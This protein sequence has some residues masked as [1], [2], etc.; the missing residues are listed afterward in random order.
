MFRYEMHTHTTPCSACGVQTMSEAVAACAAAGYAG[1]VITN[2]FY[3]G[4]SG[5]SRSLAWEE[6]VEAYAADWREGVK[7]SKEAGIDVIF[8]LEEGYASGKEVLLYGVTPEEIAAAPFLREKGLEPLSAYVRSQGGL[9]VHAHPYR[10]ASYIP[11]PDWTPD[12]ALL[13]G[14]EVY[15]AHG[16]SR[17]DLALAFAKQNGLFGT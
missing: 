16:E 12:P 10:I 9:V 1:F 7:L 15:N 11:D 2:H 14:V 13:D 3:H 8:G 4:N 5:I 17:N 6:F